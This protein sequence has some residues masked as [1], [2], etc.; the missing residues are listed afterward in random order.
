MDDN[1]PGS[2]PH[3]L[4]QNSPPPAMQAQQQNPLTP[5]QAR[6]ELAEAIHGSHEILATA[7]T[8]FKLFADTLTVDRAKL[9]VTKRQFW[10]TAEVM[11]IRIEDV[12]NVTAT[13]GPLLGT[14]TFT[15][16]V[17]NTE[18]PYSINGFWRED[19]LRLKRIT[20][21]YVIALQRGIDCSSLPTRELATMLDK[22]GIDSL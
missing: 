2:Q 21:G 20:Q 22:L 16:R 15:S 4:P 17:F 7:T 11:S 6:Q 14:V 18:K 8:A 9:T 3:T 1:K 5:Q 19:A 12:L 10:K 13:V